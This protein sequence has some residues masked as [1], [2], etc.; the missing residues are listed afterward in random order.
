MKLRT[1]RVWLEGHEEHS[2][3]VHHVNA[4]KAKYDYLLSIGDAFADGLPWTEVRCQSLGLFRPEQHR[5]ERLDELA[6]YRRLPELVLGA[7]VRESWDGKQGVI[8]GASGGYVAVIFEG[9]GVTSVCHPGE[10]EV[11]A[12]T[13]GATQ[14]TALGPMETQA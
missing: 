5:D 1:Y 8:V 6:A 2:C 7:E 13:R 9:T 12:R 4:G 10:L 11:L 14:K 3:V